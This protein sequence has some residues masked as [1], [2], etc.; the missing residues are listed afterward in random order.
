MIRHVDRDDWQRRARMAIPLAGN[1]H[2]WRRFRDLVCIVEMYEFRICDEHRGNEA[3]G[4]VLRQNTPSVA[5]V[6][7][8]GQ[9]EY[10]GEVCQTKAWATK[11]V[12][13]TEQTCGCLGRQ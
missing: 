1:L 12:E 2:G 6:L 7:V 4:V 3:D 11:G 8:Y 10:I 5:V 13:V 9:G